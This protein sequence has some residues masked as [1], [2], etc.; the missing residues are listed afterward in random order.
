M[1]Y[2]S[3][4]P[5]QAMGTGSDS[6]E[7]LLAAGET[8]QRPSPTDSN[9]SNST[10][11]LAVSPALA[12]RPSTAGTPPPSKPAGK[13]AAGKPAAKAAAGKA[14]SLAEARAAKAAARPE[15]AVQRSTPLHTPQH[16]PPREEAPRGKPAAA[17]V[18]AKK[19]VP[20]PRNA[21]WALEQRLAACCSCVFVAMFRGRPKWDA[22]HGT[23]AC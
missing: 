6:S 5:G 11:E 9:A 18:A 15:Q 1:L 12:N 8:F 14:S 22:M 21:R 19:P 16:T 3:A 17:P 20:T 23:L 2:L 4:A 10:G 7:H 13:P